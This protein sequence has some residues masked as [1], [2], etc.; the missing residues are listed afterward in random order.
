MI[1][2][3]PTHQQHAKSSLC[4]DCFPNVIIDNEDLMLS[5][6]PFVHLLL[7]VQSSCSC[8]THKQQTPQE[9]SNALSPATD[10]K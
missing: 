2:L 1:E 6:G 7:E 3:T 5:V 4:L 9:L 10:M 8:C